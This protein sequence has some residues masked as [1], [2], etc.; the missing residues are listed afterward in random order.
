VEKQ[1]S[2]PREMIP[3]EN[4]ADSIA[5]KTNNKLICFQPLNC[6]INMDDSFSYIGDADNS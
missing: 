1:L 4:A 5:I 6:L 2:A 3:S